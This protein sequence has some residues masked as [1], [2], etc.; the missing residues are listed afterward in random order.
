MTGESPKSQLEENPLPQALSETTPT[1]NATDEHESNNTLRPNDDRKD[2]TEPV[3]DWSKALL[4][5]LG[6]MKLQETSR[7][8]QIEMLLF[9]RQ[10]RKKAPEFVL[11]LAENLINWHR[12]ETSEAIENSGSEPRKR[13]FA[14]LQDDDALEAKKKVLQLDP[15]Q[16]QVRATNSEIYKHI[17]SY[18][19]KKRE[20]INESNR[21]EFLRRSS[22]TAN[23]TVTCART[24][25]QEINRNIQM[26]LD[27]VHNEDGPLA[28]SHVSSDQYVGT[29]ASSVGESKSGVDERLRNIEEH[30]NIRFARGQHFTIPERIKALEDKIIQLER[31]F[32]PWSAVHFNQPGRKYPPPPAPTIITRSSLER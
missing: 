11:E 13:S 9:S 26:K 29:Q 4:E 2:T 18:I 12:I 22:A 15:E 21:T 23:E 10:Q 7:C 17:E 32:P 14:N 25:A 19:Q 3:M 28:R 5:F 16:V 24:D 31:D 20:R 1:E 6:K 30:L 8:L 27:V